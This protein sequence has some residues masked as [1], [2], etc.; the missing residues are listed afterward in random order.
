MARWMN[1]NRVGVVN[2]YPFKEKVGGTLY[3]FFMAMEVIQ[4]GDE[5]TYRYEEH[6]W[7][8]PHD[9]AQDPVTGDKTRQQV[10]Q[11]ADLPKGTHPPGDS[12]LSAPL[13][14]IQ[15]YPQPGTELQRVTEEI[16]V[17]EGTMD[18]QTLQGATSKYY[19]SLTAQVALGEPAEKPYEDPLGELENEPVEGPNEDAQGEQSNLNLC[20][21]SPKNFTGAKK[22]RTLLTPLGMSNKE[23]LKR[24]KETSKD[25]GWEPPNSPYCSSWSSSSWSS[26][27]SSEDTR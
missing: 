2:V 22:A 19:D 6:T 23:E 21:Y 11:M 4:E 26:G 7:L 3:L 10:K 13:P 27:S 1:H 25:R 17:I 20:P 9:H 5:L 24:A 18:A 16:Y 12:Q 15:A 8:N 14:D